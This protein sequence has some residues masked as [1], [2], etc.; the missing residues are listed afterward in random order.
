MANT[1]SP[2]SGSNIEQ[3]LQDKVVL[4]IDGTNPDYRLLAVSLARRGADIV[5]VQDPVQDGH[6]D[7]TKKLV[8]AEG[9][10]CFTFPAQITDEASSM[11]IIRQTMQEFGRFDV[12]IDFSAPKV[13]EFDPDADADLAEMAERIEKKGPFPHLEFMSAVLDQMVV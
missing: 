12:F 7:E 2:P 6:L 5:I 11:E 13:V 10:R 9:R 1:K 4:I 3:T 8:E